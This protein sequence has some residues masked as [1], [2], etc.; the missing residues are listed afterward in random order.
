MKAFLFQFDSFSA[1]W[2]P[3]YLPDLPLPSDY[4]IFSTRNNV[5][6]KHCFAVFTLHVNFRFLRTRAAQTAAL[7][8]VCVCIRVLFLL[9]LLF[10]NSCADNSSAA[11]KEQ[12]DPQHEVACI[13]GR[14]RLRQLRR[15]RVGFFDFLGAVFVAVILSA[16]FAV[17]LV[18]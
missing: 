1:E 4:I 18:G 3:I 8:R 17:L 11:D 2:V 6:G 5:K 9:F 14:G 7:L 15:Y 16:A 12:C 10:G 13:A